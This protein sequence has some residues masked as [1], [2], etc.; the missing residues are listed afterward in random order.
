MKTRIKV[1]TRGDDS[2]RY[3]P[4]YKK[5]GLYWTSFDDGSY[6]IHSFSDLAYAESFLKKRTEKER[7]RKLGK[8]IQSTNYIPFP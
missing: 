3:I 6:S 5:F 1:E 4:Q 2:V 8:K 7:A